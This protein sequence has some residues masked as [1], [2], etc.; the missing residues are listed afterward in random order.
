M[1]G[2]ADT[3][4]N[5]TAG[6]IRAVAIGTGGIYTGKKKAEAESKKNDRRKTSQA[7]EFNRE[8]NFAFL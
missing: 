7:A 2:T 4:T 5:G 8:W 6:V 3:G 1:T